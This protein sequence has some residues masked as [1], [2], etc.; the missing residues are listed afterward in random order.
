MKPNNKKNI[1]R[2]HIFEKTPKNRK[3][4]KNHTTKKIYYEKNQEGM[5]IL[6]LS[7]TSSVLPITLGH[8]LHPHTRVHRENTLKRYPTMAE[9]SI[10]INSFIS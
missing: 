6:Y 3:K 8:T 2:H 5:Y 10:N 9:N 4:P 1:K 7:G